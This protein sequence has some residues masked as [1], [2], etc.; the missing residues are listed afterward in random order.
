MSSVLHVGISIFIFGLRMITICEIEQGN[1]T[2]SNSVCQIITTN[3]GVGADEATCT[4]LK[5]DWILEGK[6]TFKNSGDLNSIRCLDFFVQIVFGLSV[7]FP[8]LRGTLETA[9]CKY[10][11]SHTIA[12]QTLK[13]LYN[14]LHSLA[15]LQLPKV[16]CFRLFSQFPRLIATTAA[17]PQVLNCQKIPKTHMAIF[18]GSRNRFCVVVLSGFNLCL[19]L[20]L[21]NS[22]KPTESKGLLITKR[23]T[24]TKTLLWRIYC[25]CRTKLSI[26][27]QTSKFMI[28]MWF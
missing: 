4:S 1:M 7:H 19:E 26:G 14:K 9:S 16:N 12:M 28:I 21:R 20:Y 2:L 11:F 27:F 18:A 22:S 25:H 17:K 8:H 3:W 23:R 5:V 24:R 15:M 6:T 10:H 13:T